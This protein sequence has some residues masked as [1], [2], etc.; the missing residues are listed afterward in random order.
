[1]ANT[2][3]KWQVKKGDI[4]YLVSWFGSPDNEDETQ[5]LVC[6]SLVIV[7]SMGRQ[8]GTAHYVKGRFIKHR[9]YTGNCAPVFLRTRDEVIQLARTRGLEAYRKAKV[10]RVA[11]YQEII[12]TKGYDWAVNRKAT[13]EASSDKVRV[14]FYDGETEESVT[15]TES[16]EVSA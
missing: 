12:T 11:D 4:G 13:L 3:V 8:Q 2:A 16:R 14:W 9:I 5:G 7:D 15:V 6:A 10:Q 1:M